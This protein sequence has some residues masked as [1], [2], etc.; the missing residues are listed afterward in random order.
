MGCRCVVQ[1]RHRWRPHDLLIWDNRGALHTATP[2]DMERHRRLVYRTS[3]R[4]EVPIGWQSPSP[5]DGR[6]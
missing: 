6:A 2:Y 4:G 1:Y 3:V 5:M